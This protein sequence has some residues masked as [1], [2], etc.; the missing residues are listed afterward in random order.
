MT[1]KDRM[2]HNRSVLIQKVGEL[3][4]KISKLEKKEIIQLIQ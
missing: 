3:N 1:E 2:M 4:D